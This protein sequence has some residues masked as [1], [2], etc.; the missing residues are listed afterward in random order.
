M[1]MTGKL[2]FNQYV[3]LMQELLASPVFLKFKRFKETFVR[4]VENNVVYLNNEDNLVGIVTIDCNNCEHPL[5]D[6]DIIG[7]FLSDEIDNPTKLSDFKKRIEDDEFCL[8]L[9]VYMYNHGDVMVST[10]PFECQFDSGVLGYW[11][12]TQQELDEHFKGNREEANKYV[13]HRIEEYSEYL[14][15][16]VYTLHTFDQET[17]QYEDSVS[18]IY[19]IKKDFSTSFSEQFG[20][21]W[22]KETINI[23]WVI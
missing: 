8:L 19:N 23:I 1:K 16:N 5:R 12:F 21:N 17:F 15:G 7:K 11:V 9:P 13:K 22:E 18:G 20:G 14:Q 6:Y 2:K 3:P 4:S 10:S